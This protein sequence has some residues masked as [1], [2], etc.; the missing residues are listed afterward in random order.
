MD[1]QSDCELLANS[2][3]RE[4]KR[5]TFMGKMAELHPLQEAMRQRRKS[6]H[7]HTHTHIGAHLCQAG[8]PWEGGGTHAC[9]CR[10]KVCVRA[11]A[12]VREPF[13]LS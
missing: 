6:Q 4:T 10:Q 2:S 8:A 3:K 12:R 5:G 13:R 11:R 7:T 1:T 9:Q